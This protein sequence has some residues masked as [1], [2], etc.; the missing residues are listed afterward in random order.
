MSVMADLG[1]QFNIGRKRDPVAIVCEALSAL[2]TDVGG[3]SPL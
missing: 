1:S 2:L 3:Y